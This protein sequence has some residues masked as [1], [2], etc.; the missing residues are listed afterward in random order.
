MAGLE[1]RYAQMVFIYFANKNGSQKV[2]TVYVQN[3]L[4]NTRKIHKLK[5]LVVHKVLTVRVACLFSLSFIFLPHY[6]EN[7]FNMTK[8]GKHTIQRMVY[9]IIL[10]LL[11][12]SLTGKRVTTEA[13]KKRAKE[14]STS[15]RAS[16]MRLL[17]GRKQLKE[18][19]RR[20]E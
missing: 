3:W 5:F 2:S 4:R 16:T 8:I 19:R 6:T 17:D 20:C 14:M 11:S 15:L 18:L 7:G 10:L 1:N 9:E 13:S 12:Y